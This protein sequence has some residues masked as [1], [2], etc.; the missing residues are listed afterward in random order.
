MFCFSGNYFNV[1]GGCVQRGAS[2]LL[3]I[4]EVSALSIL[5]F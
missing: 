2:V 4:I 1:V 5:S 3:V